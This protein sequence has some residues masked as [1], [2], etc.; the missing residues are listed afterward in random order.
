MFTFKNLPFARRF[1]LISF[2]LTLVGIVVIGTWVA[3]Q[4]ESSVTSRTAVLTALYVDSFVAPHLQ[5]LTTNHQLTP[6]DIQALENLLT[7][8]PLGQQIVSFRIWL[9]DGTVAYSPIPGMA[10][11]QF[12]PG[13]AL[14]QALNGQVHTELTHLNEPEQAQEKLSWD[15]LIET[16]APVRAL[17]NGEIIAASEFYQLPDGLQ[18]EIR[19]AQFQSWFIVGGV[20]FAIYFILTGVVSWAS[21]TIEIQQQE[22]RQTVNQ[23]SNLL[24]QNQQLN[25]QA[26][27]AA[28][29]TTTL[30]EQYLRRISA[31]LHDGP[32]QDLAL[33]LLRVDS[34]ETPFSHA[35][36]DVAS[37]FR[38]VRDAIQSALTELR[39]ISAGL[40]LPEIEDATPNEIVRRAVR[41]YESKTQRSVKVEMEELPQDVP[42]SV[43]MTLYRILKETLNN[44][45]R[46]ADGKD[47]VI[48]AKAQNGYL[49]V[50]VSDNGPGFDPDAP[51]TNG[52][53][54][55]VGMRE[56]VKILGGQFEVKSNAERGTTVQVLLPISFS[57]VI[58]E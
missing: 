38:I 34:L 48:R 24:A 6:Q 32:A 18:A 39:N 53:L 22:L 10:G 31:D 20:I 28:A 41:D 35:T 2:L 17:G 58:D 51:R 50:Q 42:C 25:E 55:L 27:R 26:R 4:I 12:T 45:Y 15:I 21:K 46:H 36:P 54:G 8:T 29:R 1:M 49:M 30:N 16:Y 9:P 14:L 3:Q 56:R 44:G 40:R 47:Q 19:S 13:E 43:K 5:T 7:D 11:Q 23:Q 37:D 57:E 33:A 52:H